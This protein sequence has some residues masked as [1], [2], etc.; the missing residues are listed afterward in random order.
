MI[1][2]ADAGEGMR[3][4]TRYPTTFSLATSQP[5]NVRVDRAARF[6][7]TFAAPSLMRDTLPP[8]RSN[9]L[10]GGV[11]TA[12]WSRVSATSESVLYG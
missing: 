7:A 3:A 8:R 5:P 11:L 9:E 4:S 10:F 12:S 6:H 2:N 1:R